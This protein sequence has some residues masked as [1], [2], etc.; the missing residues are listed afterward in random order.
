MRQVILASCIATLT[1]TVFV[2]KYYLASKV[3]LLGHSVSSWYQ[4]GGTEGGHVVYIMALRFM[5]QQSVGLRVLASLQCWAFSTG[6]PML[7]VEPDMS[8]SSFTS[9]NE[10]D[11][12][13]LGNL[14][15]LQHFNT[16]SERAGYPQLI[17]RKQYSELNSK[18]AIYII[19]GRE[20]K[21]IWPKNDSDLCCPKKAIR[22][23]WLE[24]DF[25]IVK[26]VSIS[27]KSLTSQ[28]VQKILGK[29]LNLNI[30]IVFPRFG[31]WYHENCM[32]TAV[33]FHPSSRVLRDVDHYIEMH[34]ERGQF[35]ATMLRI[36]HVLH[37]R[38]KLEFK[39]CL[40][41]VVDITQK[42]QGN[43]T[44]MVAADFGKYG[45]DSW[46][47]SIPDK[48]K[49]AMA[50]RE[51]RKTLQILLGNGMSFEEWEDSFGR[52]AAGMNS[53]YVAAV[54]RTIASRAKCLVLAGGG[55]FHELA[56]K[57][58]LMFHSESEH[59]VYLICTKNEEILLHLLQQN[60]RSSI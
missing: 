29:W 27:V 18:K 7:L 15:D 52:F 38:S 2:V 1:V 9:K 46:G 54:Q 49:V 26:V 11:N 25:C 12:T 28:M 39:K 44:R 33:L 4:L 21:Q 24:E 45:S 19:I 5:G 35:I 13:S 10:H 14:F 31:P 40:H 8:G 17:S 55:R 56:L 16:L 59:C 32:D 57:E 58:Y 47:W 34:L 6:V 30:T 20:F 50:K 51:A 36:E 43:R 37:K 48:D 53:G 41:D 3:T 23:Y 42:I 22:S 60:K